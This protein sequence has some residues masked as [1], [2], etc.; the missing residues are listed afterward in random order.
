MIVKILKFL[1]NPIGNKLEQ[2]KRAL[3]EKNPNTQTSTHR[4]KLNNKKSLIQ[5]E[6]D[7]NVNETQINDKYT[8]DNSDE[9][10]AKRLDALQNSS[11]N[12]L[13]DVEISRPLTKTNLKILQNQIFRCEKMD[14][15]CDHYICSKENISNISCSRIWFLFELELTLD[16]QWNFRNKCYH[17]K[18][19]QKL[20]PTWLVENCL[21]IRTKEK[22]RKTKGSLNFEMSH[23][24]FT[25]LPD[26]T[27]LLNI[28]QD[29]SEIEVSIESII[30]ETENDND[31]THAKR[32]FI[33]PSILSFRNNDKVFDDT[34]FDIEEILNE[35]IYDSPLRTV[36]VKYKESL[37]PQRGNSKCTHQRTYFNSNLSAR[38]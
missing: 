25:S 8:R 14:S 28:K 23:I 34:I 22:D 21:D 7:N 12:S 24:I 31:L 4:R 5:R 30:E 15:L 3:S 29:R 18:V 32:K 11:L 2:K 35:D 9:V 19:Y 6:T 13:K 27:E 1:M 38:R 36:G 37:T 20:S 17:E 10:E 16:G 33:P 26:I